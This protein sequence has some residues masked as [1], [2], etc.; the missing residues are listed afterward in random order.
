MGKRIA[1]VGSNF[2]GLT[3][4]VELKKRLGKEH[5]VVVLSRTDEFLFNP[6]L[7]WVPFGLREKKDVTFP[8]API[9]EK[10]GIPFQHAAVTAIDLAGRQVVTANGTTAYDFLVIATGP[11]L[12]FTAIPGLGPHE[13]YTQSI[14]NW[15]GAALARTAFEKFLEAPGPVIVGAV[16]GAACFGAGYEFLF[17]MAYQLDKHGLTKK[18][19]LTWLTA[20]PFLAHFGI[21]GFGAGTKMTETFFGRN[22][23]E[24]IT[25]ATVREVRPGEV[26]LEDGRKLPFAYAMLVPSFL[27]VDAVRSCKDITTPAGFVKVD[28]HYRTEAYPEVYAAGV[29]VAMDPPGKTPVPC[30]VPK[31]GYLSEEMAK[32]VVHNIV[33]TIRG[34]P[35]VALPPAS[36]D[37]KCVLDAGNG[38]IVM[39]GDHFLGPRKRE[40][41]IPG[42]E[43]HWAKLAFEKYFLATRRRGRV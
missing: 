42:P 22:G 24:A 23:I 28:A 15:E 27:G 11:K 1:I 26:L 19:P 43:A 38:G 12:N 2:A 37:A 7:I 10:Y 32:V 40:W 20:E 41:L 25:N 8:L 4:A 6:S 39:L 29:A 35:L 33:A 36:I 13:G 31:T 5:E 16:Q 3:A 14:M 30:G 17:N 18:A 34:E 9:F 21:G